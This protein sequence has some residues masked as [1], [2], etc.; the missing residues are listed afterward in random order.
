MY[1]IAHA[2]DRLWHTLPIRCAAA[3]ASGY[4]IIFAVPVRRLAGEL[5]T[6]NGHRR[7]AFVATQ[8]L[9]DVLSGF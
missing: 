9:R 5:L 1:L 8:Q 7:R 2:Q 4:R 6:H 3:T